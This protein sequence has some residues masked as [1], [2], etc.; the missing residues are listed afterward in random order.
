MLR[1]K[2]PKDLWLEDLHVF[3][4]QLEVRY[5]V[6]ILTEISILLLINYICLERMENVGKK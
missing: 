2:T 3:L 5:I 1:R 6:T 4:E